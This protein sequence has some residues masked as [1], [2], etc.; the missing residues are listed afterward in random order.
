MSA[1]QQC[2]NL[3]QV[4]DAINEAGSSCFGAGYFGGT[5]TR[6]SEKMAAEYAAADV[7]DWDFWEDELEAHLDCLVEA[8]AN[9]NYALA[10]SEAKKIALENKG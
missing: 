6:S 1:I 10:L 8:G 4:V 2:N 7:Q 3:E 9:F 5:D